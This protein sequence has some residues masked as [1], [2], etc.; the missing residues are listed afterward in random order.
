[1][2]T[3]IE[4]APVPEEQHDVD[5]HASEQEIEEFNNSEEGYDYRE[6]DRMES[7]FSGDNYNGSYARRSDN[8][9]S[10]Y[11]YR[12][13]VRRQPRRREPEELTLQA[14]L[15]MVKNQEKNLYSVTWKRLQEENMDPGRIRVKGKTPFYAVYDYVTKQLFTTKKWDLW[16]PLS[17]E[18]FEKAIKVIKTPVIITR[19]HQIDDMYIPRDIEFR[20][21][22]YSRMT[23]CTFISFVGTRDYDIC[24]ETTKKYSE[25][26]L[27]Y[28]MKHCSSGIV[29]PN[30]PIFVKKD[31]T[32]GPLD[33]EKREEYREVA[34]FSDIDFYYGQLPAPTYLHRNASGVEVYGEFN[35]STV[36]QN[37]S[38]INLAFFVTYKVTE[39]IW[40]KTHPHMIK[41]QEQISELPLGYE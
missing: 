11:G 21:N 3:R 30:E 9:S 7:D 33:L 35:I 18:E 5:L 8:G 24:A 16:L 26:I 28:I 39:N 12:E 6:Q 1:M 13:K 27:N 2:S 41:L 37:I 20:Y 38:P 19:S 34:S 31:G 23:C 29:G 10:G 15:E 17:R 22:S 4:S 36:V 40:D 14:A 32:I 25:R